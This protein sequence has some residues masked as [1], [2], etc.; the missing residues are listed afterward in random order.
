MTIGAF[1]GVPSWVMTGDISELIPLAHMVTMLMAAWAC[2]R[3]LRDH[4]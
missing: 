4:F 1:L 3:A 2:R